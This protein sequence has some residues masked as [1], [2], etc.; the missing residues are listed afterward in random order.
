MFDS[1]T[2]YHRTIKFALQYWKDSEASVRRMC[3]GQWEQGKLDS[4]E[5]KPII[6]LGAPWMDTIKIWESWK[7]SLQNQRNMVQNM[8]NGRTREAWLSWGQTNY[9]AWCTLDT[10]GQS[11]ALFPSKHLLQWNVLYIAMHNLHKYVWYGRLVFNILTNCQGHGYA[12]KYGYIQS[13]WVS[14]CRTEKIF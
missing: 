2:T 9:W 4:H 6:G 11:P 12:Y 7:Y 14:L 10:G 8:R 5:G 13:I 1:L 3:N